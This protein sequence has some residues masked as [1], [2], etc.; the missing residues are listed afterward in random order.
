MAAASFLPPTTFMAEVHLESL[1]D[2]NPDLY[3][4]LPFTSLLALPKNTAVIINLPP[5]KLGLGA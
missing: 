4:E 1:L 3:K 5:C 2:P